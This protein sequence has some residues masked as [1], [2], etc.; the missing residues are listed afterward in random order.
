M[1]PTVQSD[2]DG[3]VALVTGATRGLGAAIADR[4]VALGATVYAGARSPEDVTADDRH[5][6]ELDV[7]DDGDCA[8]AIDRIESESGRL[9]VLVNNAGVMGPDTALAD[10]PVAE[11]D[12]VVETN[13][14]GP[15]VLSRAALPLLLDREAPRIVNVAS[16]MGQLNGPNDGGYPAY[17]MSK[18]ALNGL[19]TTLDGDYGHRGLLV[20][21]VCPG[22]TQTSMG[23]AD[24]PRSVDEG[25]D[26][27]V[28]L[29]RF[30]PDSPS[31]LFWRDREPM[32]Y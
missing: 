11:F 10:T 29:C 8:A 15:V 6:V 3:Q 4:L 31:G 23:G 27:P 32:E 25:A 13:F 14:R 9:D 21:A 30:E 1:D 18:A 2:L 24:A 20:N 22:W 7:T 5:V 17:R 12:R 16:D 19:T 26:T 28:W